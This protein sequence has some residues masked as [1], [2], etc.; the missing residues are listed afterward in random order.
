[1]VPSLI[2]FGNGPLAEHSKQILKTF[3]ILFHAR[4]KT[5][6]DQVKKLKL[7]HPEAFGILASFGQILKPD[8]LELFE[9]TGGIINLHPSLLPLYRGPSPIES[10]ILAGDRNFSYSIMKLETA[11]DAGPIYHQAT[12]ELPSDTP[13]SV[14][15]QTLAEAGANWLIQNLTH[16]PIPRPQDHQSATYTKKLSTELSPLDPTNHSALELHNQVRAFLQFP[17]SRFNFSGHDCI[18][19]ETSV[20]TKPTSPIHL[21]C[22]DHHYLNIH[23]LQ[24]AGKKPLSAID[25]KNGYQK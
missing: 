23:Q 22:K 9:S 12:L 13:K 19:L 3:P 24:P 16:L 25:F 8:I 11:M 15:Y 18:I 1:M 20:S 7:K 17:K 5:D 2:F 10:A 6:L 4:T 21:F 14:I